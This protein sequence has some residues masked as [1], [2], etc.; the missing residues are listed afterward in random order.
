MATKLEIRVIAD[1]RAAM[2]RVKGLVA[3]IKNEFSKIGAGAG[4]PANID[5]NQLANQIV[6]AQ[7]KIASS[8]KKSGSAA[9]KAGQKGVVIRRRAW[10]HDLTRISETFRFLVGRD[11]WA[12]WLKRAGDSAD[13]SKH[14]SPATGT[15]G[16][17]VAALRT[18]GTP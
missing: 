13:P 18:G 5:I 4:G 16:K 14:A 10:P 6:S 7:T 15:I 12:L 8:T 11:R 2:Q 17:T 1:T 9:E 3:G